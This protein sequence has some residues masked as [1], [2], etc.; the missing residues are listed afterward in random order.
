MRKTLIVGASALVLAMSAVG[1][2]Q[3]QGRPDPFQAD[4][5]SDGV[6]TRAEFDAGHAAMFARLDSNGDGALARE[7]MPRRGRH[8]GR[9]DGER[10][11]H[12]L[13]RADANNDGAISRDEFLARPLEMFGRLDANSDGVIS[14][15]ERPQASERRHR[16]GERGGR[17]DRPN[18]D[19]DNNGSVSRAEFAAH[20]AQMFDRLD[21]NDDGRVTREEADAARPRHH[22]RD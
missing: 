1:L 10:A 7:E 12:H 4:T 15:S 18:P 14:Q 3:A 2:A 17:H 16:R 21:A 5:N 22:G 13:E 9:G 8:G 19:A 11:M 20:G 6:L